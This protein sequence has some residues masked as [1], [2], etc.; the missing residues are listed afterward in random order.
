MVLTHSI[1]LSWGGAESRK[2]ALGFFFPASPNGSPQFHFFH[3]HH[4]D[5]KGFRTYIHPPSG[6]CGA[7][8]LPGF[9]SPLAVCL[10][11]QCLSLFFFFRLDQTQCSLFRGKLERVCLPKQFAFPLGKATFKAGA[12]LKWAGAVTGSHGCLH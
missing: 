6:G 5:P 2:G 3:L 9:P 8:E 7:E 11:H 4:M 1:P 12:R 10:L